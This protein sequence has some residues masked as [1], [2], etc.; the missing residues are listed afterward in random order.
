LQIQPS[1]LKIG[2]AYLTS[3]SDSF[4]YVVNTAPGEPRSTF[5]GN[6]IFANL[7]YSR[8]ICNGNLSID[9]KEQFSLSQTTPYFNQSL[10]AYYTDQLSERWSLNASAQFTYFQ[11][12]ILANPQYL[13]SYQ[14]GGPVVQTLFAVQSANTV[15]ESNSISFSY[16][17]SGRTHLTL[18][19][20]VSATILNQDGNWTFGEQ[21]GGAVGVTRD[22]TDSLNVGGFYFFSHALTSGVANSP[23]WNTQSLGVNFQYRLHNSWFF[24]GSLAASGQLVGQGWYLTPTGNVAIRKAFANSSLYGAYSRAEASNVFASSGFFDQGDVGYQQNFRQKLMANVFAGEFRTVNAGL[25]QEGK[26]I[27]GSITYKWKPRLSIQAGYNFA[28]QTGAQ[29]VTFSPLLGNTSAIS[30]GL[31]WALGSSSGP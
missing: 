28:N 27:G 3:I 29:T 11:N 22:I 24:A 18:T 6:S 8:Q 12:S 17:L 20:I 10:S 25:Q 7:V 2:P 5:V 23:G 26:R 13:L 9:G 30:F 16:E 14:N 1:G 21:F 4:F 31:N 19:P 15:Y